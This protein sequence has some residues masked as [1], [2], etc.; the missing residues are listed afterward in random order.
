[1]S[2]EEPV[3]PDLNSE[4]DS[5][6][7]DD[8]MGEIVN[9]FLVES[10]ENLDQLDQNLIDLE[11]NPGDTGILSSIFRTIHTIKGTCGF[12]GFTKLES[13]AHVGESLLSKLRD[14]EL[15]L[16]PPRTSALLAM[17]DAIRQ[18]LSC[19]ESDRNEGSVDYSELVETLTR[20]QADSAPAEAVAPVASEEAAAPAITEEAPPVAKEP[21]A[22][23]TPEPEVEIQPSAEI[24]A[25]ME[26]IVDEFLVESYENLDKLDKDLIELEQDPGN[27]D[28]LGSIFRT[29]HTIKGTCGFIGLHKLEK[30]AHVGENLL[31]K[32][33]DGV[34]A[35]D[36]PRTSALLAMVDAI[37]Q[38]L[39]CIEND[40]NEGDVDYTQLVLTLDKLLTDEGAAE[41]AAQAPA[42]AKKKEES[43]AEAAPHVAEKKDRRQATPAEEAQH[44]AKSG[45]KRT[46]P[47]RRNDTRS[48]ADSS[49]R[50]D[51]DILDR[52]MN[53][54]GELVLARNQILQFVPTGAD[55]SFIATSQHLNLV[56][57]ELQEGV[58]KTRM[59]PIGN[60]WSKFPRVVRDLSMAVGKK[61]RLEMEGKDT[62]LDKT[63]IEAIKDPLTHI[64]RNSC[65]HGIETPEKR[66]ENGKDEEGVLLLRAFHEGGQVNIEIVDDGGGIDP[67]K[68]KAKALEKEVITPEQAERM[69]DRELVNLIFAAGFSTAEK[70]TNVSGRGVGM[71]VVR[72]NIEKIGGTVDIQSRKG[73]GTT[74]RVKIPLTLAIIPALIITSGGGRYAIPQVNL[75]ELVRLDGEQAKKSVEQI[76][77][78]P[79]YR[80][81]G[82]LL[83]LV[84][85]HEELQLE[86]VVNDEAINI[87]VLHADDRQFGLV[88]EGISDTEEIVVKPL[89]EQLKGLAAFSGA[90]IM[91]DG[92][93]ALILDVMGLAQKARVI[94]EHQ[95]KTI[96]ASQSSQALQGDRQTLLIFGVEENDRIAIPLSE[97]ARLEEFKRS[98][99]EQSGDQDVVQYRGEIMPLI[100]LKKYLD[101]EGADRQGEN[102]ELMQAVVF[103]RNDR[104]VGLIVGRIIDIVTENIVVKRGA[105]RPG[106]LG[107][108][109]VQ[110]RVTDL[111]DIEAIVNDADPSFLVETT[112]LALAEEV[113]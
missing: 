77:G 37:R 75:L 113:S 102:N 2:N 83:P 41:I 48:V 6:Q 78:A 57:T 18:M 40:R 80:L 30:V 43:A 93:L 104:S 11:Q 95:E 85:L 47:D 56:T 32:L 87:V 103:T 13:V 29:I 73:K 70:V 15:D 68:I 27:T 24:D 88:V 49:I 63:L 86:K 101:V 112:D 44:V 46:T 60:I 4:E 51:V 92:K 9:E 96:A 62:E 38:M 42:V 79:V 109:V 26:P 36:P 20:L 72:T 97:V 14:G 8:G 12:I 19:I 107:T 105:N 25:D 35:L 90:T 82:N 76:Q 5:A 110:S 67:E 39:G 50:V 59:Q 17:V 100:Y 66:A 22:V 23:P 7:E 94:T 108:V 98:E 1:M 74:L 34:L 21:E 45:D 71:D 16:D 64:V 81:R 84:Y 91:G 54:V 111:L 28:I 55:S 99:I 69:G 58:M 3:A 10:Y 53:L 61:I 31:G 89:G 33:R 52:L 65:D 106:V